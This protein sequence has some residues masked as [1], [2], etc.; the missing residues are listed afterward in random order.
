VSQKFA[1]IFGPLAFGLVSQITGNARLGALTILP[2]LV[3][4][5]LVLTLV[6]IPKQSRS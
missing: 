6:R 3:L 1:G 2:F 5:G 4:G